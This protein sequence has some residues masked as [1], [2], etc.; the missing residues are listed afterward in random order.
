MTA[1]AL[2]THSRNFCDRGG[3]LLLVDALLVLLVALAA[4]VV[5][6]VH[7]EEGAAGELGP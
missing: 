5:R 4:R 2:L 1:F 6:L 7:D 3:G